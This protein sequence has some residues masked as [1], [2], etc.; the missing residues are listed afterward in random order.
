MIRAF[1]TDCIGVSSIVFAERRGQA[2]AA[3]MRDA[4][5]A[6]YKVKFTD[7]K[8]KRAPIYDNRRAINGNIPVTGKSLSAEYLEKVK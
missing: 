6:G 1:Q 5:D 4:Q 8:V 2:Q 3:T 7:V